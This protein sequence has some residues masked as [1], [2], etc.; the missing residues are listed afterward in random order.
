MRK[1]PPFHCYSPSPG[2]EDTAL[3]CPSHLSRSQ[4][5]LSPRCGLEGNSGNFIIT[6]TI[7]IKRM[8]W[9]A[10]VTPALASWKAHTSGVGLSSSCRS[11]SK[12]PQQGREADRVPGVQL[13]TGCL[14]SQ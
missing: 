8:W 9:H 2:S 5:F 1:L 11:L 7:I 13:L 12:R 14:S 6:I 10:S 4:A 3:L